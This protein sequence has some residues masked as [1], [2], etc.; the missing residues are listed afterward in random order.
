MTSHPGNGKEASAS[1]YS[2]LDSTV[3][4]PS[5]TRDASSQNAPIYI[6]PNRKIAA[7]EIPAVVQNIDRAISA[8]GR[9]P[10]FEH[11]RFSVVL[12]VPALMRASGFRPST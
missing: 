7:V 11:V 3:P 10:S 8:F 12:R 5:S 1:D 9:V 6:I 4:G 2:V